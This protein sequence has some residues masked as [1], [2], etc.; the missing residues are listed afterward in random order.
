MPCQFCKMMAPSCLVHIFIFYQSKQ[1]FSM[2]IFSFSNK[3]IWRGL[4]E[5]RTLWILSVLFNSEKK[6]TISTKPSM[7]SFLPLRKKHFL[8]FFFHIMT[9]S[10]LNGAPVYQ[11]CQKFRLRN[12]DTNWVYWATIISIQ[13]EFWVEKCILILMLVGAVYFI[14][15]SS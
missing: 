7:Q 5:N 14:S 3:N 4:F 12:P 8:H 10:F 6:K 11:E 13:N 1:S 15:P 2:G 9:P